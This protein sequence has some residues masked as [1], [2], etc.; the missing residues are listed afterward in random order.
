M[1]KFFQ[2]NEVE[3]TPA[4]GHALEEL[5]CGRFGRSKSRPPTSGLLEIA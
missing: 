4:M 1:I 5:N 2:Y 3:A